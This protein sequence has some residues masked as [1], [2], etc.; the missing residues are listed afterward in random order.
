MALPFPVLR[1]ETAMDWELRSQYTVI[2]V[3]SCP[4]EQRSSPGHPFGRMRYFKEN[5][6]FRKVF[7]KALPNDYAFFSNDPI[8]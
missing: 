1:F 7:S 5:L 6:V 3:I 4:I 2:F 8:R